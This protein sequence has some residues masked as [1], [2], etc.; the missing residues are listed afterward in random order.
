M[1]CAPP[2]RADAGSTVQAGPSLPATQSP[3]PLAARGERPSAHQPSSR[4]RGRFAPGRTTPPA[5]SL[6]CSP[7]SAC[8]AQSREG[9]PASPLP[10]LCVLA[11]NTASRALR[12]LGVGA[13]RVQDALS[14]RDELMRSLR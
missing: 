1:T 10:D 4:L 9:S 12:G 14:E 8:H 5:P 6:S 3:S 2:I 11:S 7:Y 13:D